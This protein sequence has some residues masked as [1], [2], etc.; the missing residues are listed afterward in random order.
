MSGEQQ[1][2]YEALAQ[3]AMRGVVRA[4]LLRVAKNGLPG[5]HHFY[6]AFYT[7]APGVII[8]KRIREKYPEEMTIVLQ[9]RFW[10][11]A[12][13]DDRF[14]VKL[15]FDAI[16]ERLVVPF[17]AVKVFFDPSVPYGLQFEEAGMGGAHNFRG[18]SDSDDYRETD[19]GRDGTPT[20]GT[21]SGA[22]VKIDGERTEKK[23]AQRK[24]RQTKSADVVGA[25]PPPLPQRPSEPPAKPATPRARP[26]A[27]D[28][29][30]MTEAK[31]MRPPP[32]PPAVAPDKVDDGAAKVVQLD[33]F[34]K[35]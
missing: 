14:E 16:P 35:K 10:D 1:I 6:V 19:D 30:S 31:T 27:Q 7:Q 32:T 21:R 2:D 11:L 15:T 25:N 12:V 29:A 4:V 13:H 26:V 20:R 22:S 34:R 24:A 8:S 17:D 3:D 5:E 33:K 18:A 28:S 9:H 23:P